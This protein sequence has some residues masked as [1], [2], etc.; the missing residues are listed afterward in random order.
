MRVA[1]DR[2]RRAMTAMLNEIDGVTCVEPQG[3]FYCFPERRRGCSAA[4]SR[5]G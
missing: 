2:R 4:R 5:A 3:A 1:F